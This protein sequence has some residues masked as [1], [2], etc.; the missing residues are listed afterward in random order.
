MKSEGQLGS[1]RFC[2]PAKSGSRVNKN[3]R[4]AQP[5]P[6]SPPRAH[7]SSPPK[8]IFA[9]ANMDERLDF[10]I[11][12][13]LKQY[14]S[15]PSTIP[16]PEA[17]SDLVDCEHDPESLTVPLVNAHLNP[18]V[19]AVA[20]APDAILRRCNFDT[21]AFLLK[22]AP[23][24]PAAVV[25]QRYD[26]E[27]DCPLFR[28]SRTSSIVPPPSLSKILDLVVS[29]LSTAADSAHADIESEE[30][31]Q[32]PHHKLILEVFG[33][34]LQWSIS[35][36]ETKAAEKSA[37]A[38][39]AR[40]RG[41]GAK[42]SGAN[43]ETNWDPTS[44]LQTALDIM[45]KVLKLKLSRIFVT[46]SERDTFISLFTRPVYLILESEVRVKNTTLRMHA[47]KVLCIAIKHHGHAFGESGQ[48]QCLLIHPL[49][50][51][52]C[53]NGNCPESILFRASIR[54]DGGV[55]AHLV[56]LLRLPSAG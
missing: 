45:A 4:V 34:L 5:S 15:D 55:P 42:K 11:N 41:K 49:T 24:C 2:H 52:S 8:P 38:P 54:T 32:I 13:A 29:S 21:L 39:A 14:L 44:Q 26:R 25:A 36:I 17:P 27:P 22:C 40:G 51:D 30:Q 56:R 37:S 53:A 10:S 9:F 16:T 20:E 3:I 33:F 19:D 31:D 47:F 1:E 12:D 35:A 18:V 6:T 48:S 43:K 46:S 7:L 23:I 28:L 50:C